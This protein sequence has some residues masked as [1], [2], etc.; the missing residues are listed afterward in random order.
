MLDNVP[1]C[2]DQSKK[3]SQIAY[4]SCYSKSLFT[5]TSCRNSFAP[6]KIDIINWS[7]SHKNTA[8]VETLVQMAKPQVKL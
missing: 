4:F 8:A 7:I 6:F 2:R 3:K 1:S 5:L